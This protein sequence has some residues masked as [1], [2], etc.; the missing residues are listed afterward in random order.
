MTA[1]II[2]RTASAYTYPLLIKNLFHAP[3]VDNPDQ[4]IV[5][6]DLLRY[7]YRDLRE[8]VRRL[9][10]A[11]T[12]LGVR[13]GD[14]VAVMVWDSHRYLECMFAIPMIGRDQLEDWARRTGMEVDEAARWLAPLL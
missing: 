4:E 12:E 6:R 5:Y 3:V 1:S 9:A 13:P 7:T 11:L 8:R 2:Q 14:T 10:G